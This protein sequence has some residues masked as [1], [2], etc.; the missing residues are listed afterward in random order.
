[1]SSDAW[2]DKGLTIR[3]P[4]ILLILSGK[5]IWE[6]RSQ[7]VSYRG[8][9]GLIPRGSKAVAGVARIIDSIGPLTRAD[10]MDYEHRHAVPPEMLDE[11]LANNWV[12]AW[13]LDDVI[14]LP[15]P[16]PYEHSSGAV[17]FVNLDEA[18]SSAIG[19]MLKRFEY[20]GQPA[21]EQ[22]TEP[23]GEQ[24]P[25]FVFKAQKAHARAR[26]VD[27]RKL[28]VLKGS[29]AMRNGSPDVKRDAKYRDQLVQEGVLTP[30]PNPELYVFSRDYEFESA[31]RAGGVI[32]DGN[33]SGPQSWRD[34]ATKR[35]LKNFFDNRS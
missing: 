23:V 27:G 1:M 3:E 15:R 13:V 2:V 12:H 6:M 30:S 9:I 4:W 26:I 31:S 5:K 11:V 32:K 10:Y 22:P 18:A 35:T 20:D 25:I 21:P 7:P 14:R 24:E 8:L 34:P 17:K 29:T 33:T 19:Q 28:V 16:V